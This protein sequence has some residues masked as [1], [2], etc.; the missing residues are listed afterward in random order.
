MERVSEAEVKY[1][2]TK[3]KKA[4]ILD[5]LRQKGCRIT[6]QREL[7]IDVIFEET[8]T[9]CKE[10]Y[11]LAL[12]KD[13]NIG[14]ATIYRMMNLLEEIGALKWRNEYQICATEGL[15]MNGCVVEM[16]DESLVELEPQILRQVLA[17]GMEACGLFHGKEVRHVIVKEV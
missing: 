16:E 2:K 4:V 14:M 7:L 10:I 5:R 11:Y 13:P 9:C 12:K 15:Q 1:Q 8:A 6:R 3:L 17:K